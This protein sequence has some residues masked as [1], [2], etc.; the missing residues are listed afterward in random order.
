MSNQC[1]NCPYSNEA[2]QLDLFKPILTECKDCLFKNLEA[3]NSDQSAKP[4]QQ[5]IEPP[6]YFV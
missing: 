6:V 5:S 3:T 4:K 1:E 2:I